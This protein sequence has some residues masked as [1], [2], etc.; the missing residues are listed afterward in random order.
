MDDTWPWKRNCSGDVANRPANT[1]DHAVN[2]ANDDDDE[3]VAVDDDDAAVVVVVDGRAIN[4][5]DDYYRRKKIEA[6]TSCR[7]G[8]RCRRY[9]P[10]REEDIRTEDYFQASNKESS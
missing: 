2:G 10:D 7:R 9:L 4:D 1:R 6:R 3:S 8:R 5:E